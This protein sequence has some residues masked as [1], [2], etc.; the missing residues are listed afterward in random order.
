MAK[1]KYKHGDR[2]LDGY[3]IQRGA[4]R[5]GFG[6]VYYAVSD[7]GKE[8]AL[9]TI[10]NYASIELRGITQCM[11]LKSPH[12]VTIFDVKYNHNEEPFVIMEFVNGPSLADLINE[13][14]GGLGTQKAAFFLRE[15]AKGLSYL[16]DCGIVHRDLKPGNI[17]YENGSVK[18]GDYGLSKAINTTQH[19]GQ[20]ITVGTV[21]YM[22]PEI[23]E[24]KYDRGIDIY[25]L[26]IVLYEMLTGQVPYFGASPAEVLMKHM[27]SEP[28]LSNI[29]QTFARVIRKALAKDP[30]ERYNTVQEMVEDVFGSDH[31]RNSVSQ[32]RPESLSMIAEQVA[33]KVRGASNDNVG[34][35]QQQRPGQQQ[36]P[37]RDFAHGENIPRLSAR[38]EDPVTEKQRMTLA[39][40]AAAAIALTAGFF[41]G[42]IIPVT[43][44][45]LLAAFGLSKIIIMSRFS[46]FANME[47]EGPWMRRLAIGG[48][49]SFALIAASVILSR[50]G[51]GYISK[52]FLIKSLIALFIIDWWKLTSPKR[53]DRISLGWALIVGVI[54]FFA[55]TGWDDNP[56]LSAFVIAGTILI[57]QIQSPYNMT[58][59]GVAKF[60]GTYT[61]PKEKPARSFSSSTGGNINCSGYNRTVTLL[62]TSGMFLGMCG[63]HRIY[64]GK[65]GTGILWLCTGGLLGFGQLVDIIMILTGG[66]KDKYGKFVDDWDAGNMSATAK[67]H[68]NRP[69][70]TEDGNT[71]NVNNNSANSNPQGSEQP[72]ASNDPP[73]GSSQ[74]VVVQLPRE[75]INPIS[76]VFSLLGGI[77]M[78]A[79]LALGFAAALHVPE[80]LAAG[81]P[82]PEIAEDLTEVFGTEAWQGLLTKLLVAGMF[83]FGLIS[84]VCKIFGRQHTSVLCIL[85][86]VFGVGGMVMGLVILNGAIYF[87]NSEMLAENNMWVIFARMLDGANEGVMAAGVVF[88]IS[89]VLLSW[90]YKRKEPKYITVNNSNGGNNV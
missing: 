34:A 86:A 81:I 9:K 72:F 57:T 89:A 60:K 50:I 2:P 41:Q 70:W 83:F 32:F 84:V 85:R 11:N 77:F 44:F 21:H 54:V 43:V 4:G 63:L 45:T 42:N 1:F 27:S 55:G 65:I 56:H 51:I 15:I 64:V 28:D 13:S 35:N 23:G 73:S 37:F 61:K 69:H 39:L 36:R 40:I 53:K 18:I 52:E 12:L 74:Q 30:K 67:K 78:L 75:R 88:V 10:Q 47:K 76:W 38:V 5:G 14:N 80:I 46:W 16:H 6:E 79:T 82:D 24:G 8:V 26:G 20:T 71:V 49:A 7:A 90:P 17:F 29:D 62:L 58:K 19:S 31:I 48:V 33:K 3:T 22:A 87:D 59:T 25:A 66:F 68:Y